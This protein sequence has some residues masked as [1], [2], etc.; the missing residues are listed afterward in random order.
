MRNGRHLKNRKIT[1]K[2]MA[3]RHGQLT[4][5]HLSLILE[6]FKYLY[7]FACVWPTALKLG[8]VT[9]LDT[10]FL[11]MISLIDE[12]QFMLIS[13]RHICIRSIKYCNLVDWSP[14]DL[15]FQHLLCQYQDACTSPDRGKVL[16]HK[17]PRNQRW[18]SS[19]TG[20]QHQE[21]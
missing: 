10:L 11:V 9:N 20:H 5:T 3:V 1:E 19:S 7:H 2:C 13:S 17:G 6:F 12:I 16:A 4:T 8:C 15:C 18:S 21:T 14:L